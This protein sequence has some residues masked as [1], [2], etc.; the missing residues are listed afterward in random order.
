MRKEESSKFN[1]KKTKW[2][3]RFLVIL[4]ILLLL[5]LG[6]LLFL[7]LQF[8][9]NNRNGYI[10]RNIEYSEIIKKNYIDGFLDTKNSGKFA[11]ILPKE[12]IN[13]LLAIGQDRVNDKYVESIYFDVDESNHAYFFVDLKNTFVKTRVVIATTISLKDSST[14]KLSISSVSMGKMNA[15]N[16]VRSKGYLDKN[17]VDNYFKACHLPVKFDESNLAFEITPY[18][19]INMFPKSNIVMELFQNALDRANVISL[20]TSIFGFNVDI[21]KLR[22]S[23]ISYIDHDTSY[24]PNVSSELLDA[25]ESNYSTM[26]SGESRVVYS[27][28]ESSLNKIINSSFVSTQKEE[29]TSTLT[30]N[31]VIYDFKGVNIH[32]NEV[33]KITLKMY[34]SI[35]GYLID[36][37]TYLNVSTSP[38]SEFKC[39]Y[40]VNETSSSNVKE[41]VTTILNSLNDEYVYFTY[42]Q[43][44]NM[45]VIDFTCL[46]SQYS[47]P[48]I[49]YAPK[50][51]SINPIEHTLEFI[52]TNE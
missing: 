50:E 42:Q 35:N 14:I 3:I 37:D 41:S 12:D 23:D 48:F 31:K 22:S 51:I 24:I 13:E 2:L 52:L 6:I 16:I 30:S 33:D 34:Y 21:S 17:Y 32:L 45:F 46:N 5:T 49:K 36:V 15:F 26:S 4:S 25:V 8:K 29:I 44:N 38:I 28:S 39:N 7:L 11:Y 19:F 18:N 10:R 9:D 47:D 1:K 20:N 43:S 27:L 40:L